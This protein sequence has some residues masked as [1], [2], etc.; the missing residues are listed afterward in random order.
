MTTISNA[1]YAAT[2]TYV[3]SDDIIDEIRE[4]ISSAAMD[5]GK[6]WVTG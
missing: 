6:Q 2:N 1:L 5:N 3:N 4:A